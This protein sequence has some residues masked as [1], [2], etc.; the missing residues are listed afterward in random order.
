MIRD[1]AVDLGGGLRSFPFFYA[2][3][4]VIKKVYLPTFV[5]GI[6]ESRKNVGEEGLLHEKLLVQECSS[7][8]KSDQ[9]IL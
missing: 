1:H 8:A 6:R 7:V 2:S 5:M 3:R 4:N 9:L